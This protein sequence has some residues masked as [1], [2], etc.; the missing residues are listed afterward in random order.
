M[1]LD[2]KR[3]DIK[4]LIEWTLYI[5]VALFPFISYMGYLF[6]GTATRAVNLVVVI[7]ILTVVFGISLLSP[8][9]RIALAKSPITI[10]LFA[11][12]VLLIVSGVQGVD[13]ATSFWSKATRMTGIYYFLHLGLFYLFLLMIFREEEKLRKFIKIFLISA[14]VFSIGALLYKDGFN[15][16]LQTK[17]WTGFTFGNSSFAA[18]YMYAAFLLCIYIVRSQ[19]VADRRWWKHFLPLVFIINPYIINRDLWLGKVNILQNPIGIIGEAQASSIALL[20]SI[21]ILFTA[22][23]ISKIRSVSIRLTVMWISIGIGVVVMSVSVYSF[24]T[25]GGTL[26]DLYLRQATSARPIVWELSKKSIHLAPTLGW[27]TDNFDRAFEKNYDNRLLEQRNGAEPWFD[28][29]HNIFI[30]QTVETG[31]VGLGMY[32]LVYAVIVGC[33]VYVL[34]RSKEK[35]DHTLAVISIV[36]VVGHI[37]ELQTGFDTT[38]SYVPLALMTALAASLF[39]KVYRAQRGEESEWV[40]QPPAQYIVA[41]TLIVG[42]GLLF[43]VGTVPIIRAESANGAIRPAGSSERRMTFYPKLFGSP[44]DLPTF[45]WR[46]S[47]DLQRG[48]AEKPAVLEDPKKREGFVKEL[49]LYTDY[50]RKYLEQHPDDFRSHTTLASIYIYERLFEVDHLNEAHAVLDR[51]ITL[52][53]QAPQS[54]WMKSVAYLYQRK[55]DLAR[56]WAKKA[57]D[58]NPGIEQS[59]KL[60]EYID[61]SIQTFPEINLY[62]FRQI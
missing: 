27:G 33:M 4:T 54:Y 59:K 44:V 52:V 37:M 46:T 23:I 6:Y 21:A 28:R 22:W 50:Y 56:Q 57:Y 9:R 40:L 29:A 36:Y 11:F 2:T 10:S 61:R 14:G 30:D 43:F 12:L 55:F 32:V 34:L 45:L 62:T 51:A 3:S 42:F 5:F 16:I 18:M 31:Y 53:P 20:S 26:Q 58:L 15:I 41:T 49:A 17:E 48:I 8:R 13:V 7:E 25:P 19:R 35:N 38:I 47:S 60:I 24:L 39:H 1:F